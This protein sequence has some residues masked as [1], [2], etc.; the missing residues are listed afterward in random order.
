M[1]RGS[2]RDI[3]ADVERKYSPP[4]I[5]QAV[6]A[7]PYVRPA[8]LLRPPLALSNRVLS[9][10]AGMFTGAGTWAG[11]PAPAASAPMANTTSPRTATV[12]RSLSRASFKGPPPSATLARA[13]SLV[14][15]AQLRI[16]RSEPGGFSGQLPGGE[17][18]TEAQRHRGPEKSSSRKTEL[19]REKYE[20]TWRLDHEYGVLVSH[21]ALFGVDTLPQVFG[22]GKHPAMG[23]AVVVSEIPGQALRDKTVHHTWL[24]L[25]QP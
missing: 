22:Q 6:P 10:A 18:A 9:L 12:H 16:R 13:S 3:A 20:G 19:R 14:K 15:P 5:A 2:R 7:N 8:P 17:S 23:D 25:R 11:A 4:G 21:D 24:N 1:N